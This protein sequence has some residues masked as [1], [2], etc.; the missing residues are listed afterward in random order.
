MKRAAILIACIC[1][2]TASYAEGL[3]GKLCDRTLRLDYVFTGGTTPTSVALVRMSSTEGWF[4]RTVNMDSV[5]VQGNGEICLVDEAS[6]EILYRNSFSTLFQEWLTSAEAK[7]MTKAFENTFIVPMPADRAVVR[8]KLFDTHNNVF[9]E[10]SSPVDPEDILIERKLPSDVLARFIHKGGDSRRCIDVVILAEGY[11]GAERDI[12]FKDAEIAVESI[13]AHEPFANRR[14]D[15]NFI[16]VAP[17][18]DASGVSV[19]R[20]GKWFNT[21]VASHF[22][23]F[24]TDRYLTTERLFLVHDILD[25]LPYEHIIILANTD[26]YGGGGIYNSYTL[27]TAHHPSFRPVVVHEFGHSFGALADE[28]DYASTEDPFYHSDVE[29]WEQNITTKFDFDSKWKDMIDAGVKGV[30]L[31]EGAGYQ[32]KD[33]WRPVEDCRMRT[34][35]AGEF[36]PVCQRAI[37]RIILFNTKEIKK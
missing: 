1:L 37:D 11:T 19:P 34:N 2:A 32:S 29:P 25:G 7:A 28:Y 10:Y 24:Y 23:T 22:D 20:E 8:I 30:G 13:F 31:F 14:D 9:C 16:A 36:C 35:A 6:G 4:G 21:P 27:T 3:G 33:V 18:S 5:P 15:F 12:F 17:E 26:V